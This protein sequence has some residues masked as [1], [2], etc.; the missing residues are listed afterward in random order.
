M[1]E[2]KVEI[3]FPTI[4]R[5]HCIDLILKN[6]ELANK[7]KNTQILCVCAGSDK[8]K[9]YVKRNLEKIFKK[10]NFIENPDEGIEHDKLRSVSKGEKDWTNEINIKKIENVYKTYSLAKENID[11]D[12][13]YYWFIEDDTLFPL[14]IFN[15]YFNLLKGLKADIITGVSYYWHEFGVSPRNF[16]NL[17]VTKVFGED[18]NSS[19]FTFNITPMNKQ[20]EGVVKLGASGLGNVLAKK[21]VILEWQPQEHTNI[22]SGADISFFYNAYLKGFIA[23]GVWDIYLPHITKY[24]NG[25]IAILGRIDKSLIPLLKNNKSYG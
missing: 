18:D 14:D 3:L 5:W 20:D 10:V 21:E 4:E 7:P 2:A 16:W 24:E 22:G 1:N 11:K 15:R 13:D 17:E 23:Y 25:D 6:M 12:V 8:Y 9:N 19:E